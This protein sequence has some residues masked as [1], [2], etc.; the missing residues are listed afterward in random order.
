MPRLFNPECSRVMRILIAWAPIT[1]VHFY[2]LSSNRLWSK[3]R[4]GRATRQ[5]SRLNLA[6]ANLIA[7]LVI[8]YPCATGLTLIRFR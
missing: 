8:I 2:I 1:V 4:L 5:K 6:V 3:T 7:C